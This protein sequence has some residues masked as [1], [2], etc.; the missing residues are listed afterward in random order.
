[1]AGE[2][3][4]LRQITRRIVWGTLPFQSFRDSCKR[5]LCSPAID[6]GRDGS[7][8]TPPGRE[9]NLRIDAVPG[10]G[11]IPASPEATRLDLKGLSASDG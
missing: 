6:V 10:P 5:G 9:G 2:P 3:G 1:M 8:P 11:C 7:S 4:L